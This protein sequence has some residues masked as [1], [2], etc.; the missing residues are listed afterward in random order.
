MSRPRIF[1]RVTPLTRL[2]F[3][4][5][6]NAWERAGLDED[7]PPLV[8]DGPPP[9]AGG[10]VV[11]YSF[12]TPQLPG[13]HEEITS[14][15]KKGVILVA[16]GPHAAVENDLTR[17]LGFHTRITGDGEPAI[18]RLGRLLREGA[19]SLP[20]VIDGG[21]ENDFSA[22]LP[23]T[24]HMKTLP[25]IELM[26]GCSR[27]CAYCVTGSTTSPRFR[28]GTSVVEY[29]R[30]L[31]ERGVNRINFLCPCA[32]EYHD[33]ESGFDTR[34]SL[35]ALLEKAGS[36]GFRH[37]EYGIFPSEIRPDSLDSEWLKLLRK[38]VSNRRITL[39]AQSGSDQR[40]R[41]IG[42]GHS[43]HRVEQAVIL[44]NEQG[45]TVNL[46]FIVGYPDESPSEL[47]VT[48][49]FIRHL[50]GSNRIH[51]QVHHFFPL[52]GTPL[53]NRNPTFHADAEIRLLERLHQ[54][55]LITRQWRIN[56]DE[57]SRYLEWMRNHFPDLHERFH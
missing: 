31:R 36:A 41:A 35:A 37:V 52:P 56:M 39:G 4:V 43:R 20:E 6:L 50:H 18:L 34:D 22:W 23:V 10:D 14:L 33:P 5:L 16:G 7:F 38:H 9:A 2:S 1:F 48:L 29:M 51:A 45:F 57:A 55:G 11:L 26:R 53:G 32:L 8:V 19:T 40:L 27:H 49:D 12:L 30:V 25:P 44:A 21:R 17:K 46:D 47:R 54:D 42:R 3:P 13:L 15:K 28:A 24:R